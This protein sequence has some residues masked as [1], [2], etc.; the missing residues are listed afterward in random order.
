MSVSSREAVFVIPIV[1][2]VGI[3]SLSVSSK[4]S[5][6]VLPYISLSVSSKDFVIVL[7][8]LLSLP[9]SSKLRVIV[10]AEKLFS[11]ISLIIYS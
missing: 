8:K 3:I 7:P 11:N 1:S 10:E 6:I 5:V 2:K 9:E 4:D